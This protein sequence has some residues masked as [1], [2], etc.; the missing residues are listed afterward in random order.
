MSITAQERSF[1]GPLFI[2]FVLLLSLTLGIGIVATGTYAIYALIGALL[3]IAFVSQPVLGVYLTTALLLLSGSTGIIGFV[4]E[5]EGVALTLARITGTAALSAWLINLLLFKNN[6]RYN[7][8]VIYLCAFVAWAFVCT[9]LAWDRPLQ[10]PEWVRLVTVLGFFLLAI[11]TLN[12]PRKLHIFVLVL[13]FCGVAMSLTAVAQYLLPQHQLAGADA[14][15]GLGAVDAAYIDQE[16]LQGEAAIRASGRAGHS[17]WLAFTILLILP[18]SLY[19][20]GAVRSRTL[21]LLV[22][23]SVAV[24]GIALVLTYTRVGFLIGLVL[25]A[26]LV[27]KKLVRVTPLRV[28]VGL[29]FV[30]IAGYTMLPQAY[31]ERVFMPRQYVGSES[32]LSRL[33]MQESATQYLMQNPVFGL[34]LGGFGINF[35]RENNTTAQTMRFMV[36]HQGWNAIFVGTHNM[37]LEIGS[38][39]GLP[40]LILFG[41]FYIILI[42]KIYVAEQEFLRAGDIQGA[43]LAA[44]LFVSLVG[45]MLCS[46]FLHALTQ[47]IWWMIAAGAAVIPL[48]N[49][50]FKD[51][52]TKR[53]HTTMEDPRAKEPPPPGAPEAPAP[54]PAPQA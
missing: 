43:N 32:V 33:Q 16:S 34:G 52:V 35:I 47:K 53:F 21:K 12:T 23:L 13:L 18:L 46:V 49:M 26:L 7:S 3:F 22:I 28:F 45:F 38:S 20:Y 40:G 8:A 39:T 6:F 19:W 30:L 25:A 10:V 42:R 4:G 29:L 15:A 37:W 54:A 41:L 51:G 50:S 1:T 2:A 5:T 31:K 44:A 11:N 14:W 36:D 24:M 27:G 17:N 9:L 48:Y